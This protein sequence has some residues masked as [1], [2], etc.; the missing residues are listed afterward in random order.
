MTLTALTPRLPVPALNVPLTTGER[1]V[2]GASLGETGNNEL[3]QD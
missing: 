1:F 3:R 2:L